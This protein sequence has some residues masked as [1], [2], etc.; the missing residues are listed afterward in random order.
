MLQSVLSYMLHKDMCCCPSIRHKVLSRVLISWFFVVCFLYIIY[1][2]N[3]LQLTL[4]LLFPTQLLF[5]WLFFPCTAPKILFEIEKGVVLKSHGQKLCFI[6][7]YFGL[8][9]SLLLFICLESG[10]FMQKMQKGRAP[11][12]GGTSTR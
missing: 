1:A 8:V 11:C 12:L 7:K 10:H 6:S 2:S 4:L 5:L 3:L 9:A